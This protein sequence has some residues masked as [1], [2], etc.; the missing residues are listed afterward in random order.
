MEAEGLIRRSQEGRANRL[1]LTERG[2]ELSV[3]VLP[4]QE[5][6][7]TRQ[8]ASLSCE[9]QILLRGVLRK[10]DHALG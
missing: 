9:E 2:R 8:F 3:R 1:F 10:V 4:A 7:I 5:A 6:L